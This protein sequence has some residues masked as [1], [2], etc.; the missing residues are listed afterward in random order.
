MRKRELK[1][2]YS[3]RLLKEKALPMFLRHFSVPEKAISGARKPADLICLLSLPH[4]LNLTRLREKERTCWSRS[5]E[6]AR[7]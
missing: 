6:C 3:S 7:A 2:C 1:T 5:G 4:S